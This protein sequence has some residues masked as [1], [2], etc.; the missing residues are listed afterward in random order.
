[1]PSVKVELGTKFNKAFTHEVKARALF[2]T[3]EDAQFPRVIDSIFMNPETFELDTTYANPYA[4]NNKENSRIYH[5]SYSGKNRRAVN[6]FSY[7]IGLEQQSYTDGLGDKQNYLRTNLEL[8]TAY[9]YDKDRSLDFRFYF[10]YMLQNSKRKSG[11]VSD[12]SSRGSF[13]LTHQGYN[14]YKYDNF[15]FGRNEDSGIWSQQVNME[16]G[17]M[18]N[19]FGSSFADGQSN[20]FIFALNFSADLP[21]SLPLNLPVKPYFD[22]GYF[23]NK[24]PIASDNSFSDQ[25]WY[26]GGVMLEFVDVFSVHFPFL[27]SD[28]IKS[29]NDQRGNYWARITWKLDLNKANPFEI[30][31]NFSF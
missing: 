25:V 28:N 16:E 12:P 10:G 15:H 29:L 13:A 1:M 19:A 14:D 23:S 7:E 30:I 21:I 18:K 3:E 26:S 2:I 31:D 11:I 4:G 8:N 5:I 22:I 20:D 9:T 24:S 27:F 17:G 6:P